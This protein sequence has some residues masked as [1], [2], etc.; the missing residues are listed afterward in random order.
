M[1]GQNLRIAGCERIL[2]KT[3]MR[4]K[5]KAI[6]KFRDLLEKYAEQLAEKAAEATRHR[7][8]K[9]IIEEDLNFVSNE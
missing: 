7:K 4:V 2:R 9:T 6:Y 5:P 3:G 1:N 8:K